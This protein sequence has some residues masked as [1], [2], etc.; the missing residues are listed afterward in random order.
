MMAPSDIDNDASV[1]LVGLERAKE[2]GLENEY[3]DYFLAEFLRTRCAVQAR[4]HALRE[5]DL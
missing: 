3:T 5:W 4:W 2:F 1:F